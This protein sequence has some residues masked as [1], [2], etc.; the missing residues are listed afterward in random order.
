MK[1]YM[2]Q[3]TNQL[4]RI[5]IG[6]IV[7]AAAVIAGTGLVYAAGPIKIMPWTQ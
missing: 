7:L 5:I 2:K 4:R 3:C 1:Q 6:M